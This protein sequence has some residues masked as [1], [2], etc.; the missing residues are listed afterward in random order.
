MRN[1]KATHFHTILMR[2]NSSY[3]H[4]DFIFEAEHSFNKKRKLGDWQV[5]V[6]AQILLKEMEAVI[7]FLQGIAHKLN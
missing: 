2:T 7:T 6:E 3:K 5:I 1:I 4:V